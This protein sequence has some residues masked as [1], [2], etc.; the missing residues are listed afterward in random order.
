MASLELTDKGYE[1]AWL[2]LKSRYDNKRVLLATHMRA[3][4]SSAAATKASPADLKQLVSVALRARRSFEALG[5]PVDHWNDWFVHVIVEKMDSSSRLLWEASLQTSTEFPTFI[6]LQDFLHTRIRALDAASVRG[7]TTAVVPAAKPQDKKGKVT[8]LTAS[9]DTTSG[10]SKQCTICRGNHPF[11]Y[12][13]RFK[14]YSVSQ[15][16]EYVKKSGACYNCLKTKHAV[17]SCPSGQRCRR[18]QEKHHTLLHPP[19]AASVPSPEVPDRDAGAKDKPVQQDPHTAATGSSGIA[20]HTTTLARS[21]LLATAQ[22]TVKNSQQETIVIRALLDSRSEASFLSERV[23]R[24]LR[25]PRRRVHVPVSGV[26]GASAGIVNHAVSVTLGSLRASDVEVCIPVAFLLPKVTSLLPRCRVARARWPHLI[27]LDLADPHY[28]RPAAMDAIL[29]ADIYGQLLRDGTRRGSSGTPSAQSTAL[30][31][32]L[33]GQVPSPEE[34]VE[35]QRHVSAHCAPTSNEDLGRALQRFW[36]IEE[37]SGGQTKT[38]ENQYCE[39]M[40]ANMH[41]RD[42]EGRYTVRLPKKQHSAV[43]LANNRGEA[44]RMLLSLERRLLRNPQLRDQ[45]T[46][47]MAEY[48]SLGHMEV[49]PAKEVHRDDACYLPHHAVFKKSDT[50]S[51]IRV[52]FNASHPTSSG[53]SLNDLLLPGPRLQSELWLILTRW[54]LHRYAFAADIKKMFRQILVRPEDTHLQ[55]VL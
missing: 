15:R 52:V 47:F 12:C 50:G 45:Y 30:G 9:T 39:T 37:G 14:A 40:F 11:N 10:N 44:L 18:C 19:D 20:S 41:S 4:F 28:D 24:A 31:W 51:K 32:V 54:R 5:R 7:S 55:R 29:G 49:I 33:M 3:F 25:L 6:Q 42:S 53:Y 8:S 43:R 34:S 27:G 35:E 16:R 21:V 48:L 13:L 23:A 36:E 22:V 46:S 26:R 38:P 17:S 1:T 2:E